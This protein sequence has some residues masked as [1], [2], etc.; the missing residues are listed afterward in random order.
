MDHFDAASVERAT[1][2]LYAEISRGS[3]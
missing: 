3:G 1:L 2:A